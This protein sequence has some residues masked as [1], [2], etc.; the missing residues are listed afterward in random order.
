MSIT[1][2]ITLATTETRPK[3][4]HPEPTHYPDPNSRTLLVATCTAMRQPEKVVQFRVYFN[5]IIGAR[6][7]GPYSRSQKA[8]YNP[9]KGFLVRLSKS[10]WI[11]GLGL[12]CACNGLLLQSSAKLILGGFHI[13]QREFRNGSVMGWLYKGLMRALC[14]FFQ[15]S[16]RVRVRVFN[17]GFSVSSGFGDC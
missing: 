8:L 2:T 10:C 11:C 13:V 9:Y 16:K 5:R 15:G 6:I 1:N 14:R 3:P 4:K 12:H 7:L 17:K